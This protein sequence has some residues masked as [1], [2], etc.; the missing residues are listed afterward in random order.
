[1]EPHRGILISRVPVEGVGGL[2]FALGM[3]CVALMA[4]PEI[5]LLALISLVGGALLA[6]VLV[7]LHH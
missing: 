3:V 2:I 5:R 1:M 7:K 4:M 6:P